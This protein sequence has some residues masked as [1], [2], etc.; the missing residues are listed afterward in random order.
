MKAERKEGRKGGREGGRKWGEKKAH[1]RVY[2][3]VLTFEGT[4]I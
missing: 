2:C 3:W 1:G 4:D